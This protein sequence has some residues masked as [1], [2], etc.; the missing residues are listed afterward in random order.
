MIDVVYPIA[1]MSKGRDD[2]ELKYSL[3]SL[4]LQNWVGNVYLIG[5]RPKLAESV[6]HIPCGDP[7]IACKDANI[8]NKIMVACAAPGISKTFMVNS[9][10]QYFLKAV[11]V[12]DLYPVLEDPCRLSEFKARTGVNC[13]YKRVIDTVRGCVNEG[14]PDWIFQSHIPYLV[15]KQDYIPAMAQIPWGRSTGFTTHAYLNM[16]YKFHPT[17]EAK[18]RTLRVK[19]RMDEAEFRKTV[20]Q[21]TFLNHNDAGLTPLVK[22]FLEEYFPVPSR[23]ER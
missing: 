5:H 16:T 2:F 8:I 21:A 23:W 22:N 14:F 3:R 19:G 4:M 9:D 12:E 11:D 10:D 15:D 1:N 18:G 13:W 17:K 7:Y 20:K 6:I